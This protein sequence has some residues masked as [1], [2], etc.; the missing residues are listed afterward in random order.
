MDIFFFQKFFFKNK[1]EAYLIRHA[2]PTTIELQE[3][4]SLVPHP[5]KNDIATIRVYLFQPDMRYECEICN[6]KLKISTRQ[7]RFGDKEF[8]RCEQN[9]TMHLTLK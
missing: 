9:T 3:A 4:N 1:Q 8:A 5:I 6:K 7:K 2:K